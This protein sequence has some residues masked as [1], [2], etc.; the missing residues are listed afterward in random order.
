[1]NADNQIDISLL[2]E[3]QRLIYDQVLQGQNVMFTGLAGS[4]KSFLI[5]ALVQALPTYSWYYKY[6]MI[7]RSSN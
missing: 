1:M 5:H 2:N 3:T 4:G 7:F 6:N